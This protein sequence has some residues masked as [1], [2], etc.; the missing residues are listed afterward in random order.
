MTAVVW[1]PNGEKCPDTNVVNG[2]G[3]VVEYYDDGAEYGRRAYTEGSCGEDILS[4]IAASEL[5]SGRRRG[6]SNAIDL[7]R[8]F[9]NPTSYDT[10]R[11]DG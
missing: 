1:K 10:W 3:V 7:E 8:P 2:N 5:A 9:Q 11:D 6:K 4:M